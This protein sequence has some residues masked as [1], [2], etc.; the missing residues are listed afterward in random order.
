MKSIFMNKSDLYKSNNPINF[1]NNNL[2]CYRISKEYNNYDKESFNPR[3]CFRWLLIIGLIDEFDPSLYNADEYATMA[4]CAAEDA[5]VPLD[6]AK[7]V[8][9]I[10]YMTITE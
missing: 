5:G 8:Y 6:D 3:K 1:I 2:G 9:D 7:R 4:Q 10:V